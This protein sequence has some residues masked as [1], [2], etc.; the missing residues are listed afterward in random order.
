MTDDMRSEVLATA[1][2]ISRMVISG[3]IPIHRAK[4]FSLGKATG[5]KRS[6]KTV[7]LGI[8]PCKPTVRCFRGPGYGFRHDAF[9][10]YLPTSQ[11]E[12][13]LN[14]MTIYR[15]TEEMNCFELA[16]M[17]L[18]VS[19][20]TPP[21]A[22]G[23]LLV[24]REHVLTLPAVEK[25]LELHESDRLAADLSADREFSSNQCFVENSSGSVS[26]LRFHREHKGAGWTVQ[27]DTFDKVH[28]VSP[29][30]SRDTFIF[31]NAPVLQ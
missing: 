9:E 22:L 7:E 19:D 16:A 5:E 31:R 8:S 29:Y 2:K 14:P 4:R 13:S 20:E 12:R 6:Y 1:E 28:G 25:L 3:E 17:V 26:L 10:Q 21:K 18:G 24:E 23:K 27:L 11:Q 30:M 15:P